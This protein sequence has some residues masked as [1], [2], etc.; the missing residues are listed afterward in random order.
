MFF[1]FE[2]FSLVKS[3]PF[4]AGVAVLDRRVKGADSGLVAVNEISIEVDDEVFVFGI[5]GLEHGEKLAVEFEKVFWLL[6][7]VRESV[8]GDNDDVFGADPE[9]VSR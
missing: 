2:D 6:G 3:E 1:E 7:D 9:G 8:F 5:E 4:P